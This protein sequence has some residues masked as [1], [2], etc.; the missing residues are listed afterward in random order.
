MDI[1]NIKEWKIFSKNKR[2]S[3]KH[4]NQDEKIINIKEMKLRVR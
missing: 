1:E 2:F 4:I 3:V